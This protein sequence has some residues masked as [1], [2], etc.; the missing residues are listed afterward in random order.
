MFVRDLFKMGI[1]WLKLFKPARTR[2]PDLLNLHFCERID[3]RRVGVYFDLNFAFAGSQVLFLGL[4]MFV[5][6]FFKMGNH[7]LKLFKPACTRFQGLVNLQLAKNSIFAAGEFEARHPNHKEKV[8]LEHKNPVVN[9]WWRLLETADLDGAEVEV[10]PAEEVIMDESMWGVS[11]LIFTEPMG[12]LTSSLLLFLLVLNVICQILFIWILGSTDLTQ[13]TYTPN[14]VAQYRNW[15]RVDAHAVNNYDALTETILS[16]RVCD[17]TV[18]SVAA[19]V[20]DAFGTV[21]EY[22]GDLGSK[23]ILMCGMSLIAWFMT[24]EDEVNS[25]ID[26][27]KLT[28]SIPFGDRT[29]IN[30]NNWGGYNL[31]QLSY[32]RLGIR[33]CVSAARMIIAFC[34]LIQGANY[35]SFTIAMGDLLLNAVA[36]EFVINTDELFF[37]SLAPARAKRVLRMTQGFKLAAVKTF[38]GL[39]LECLWEL[40]FL[41][42][43]MVWVT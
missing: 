36:L 19:E 39:D 10:E 4:G 38:Q 40:L 30:K 15:R 25:T 26:S 1:H 7:W 14:L 12:V 20:S 13:P 32:G 35:L 21:D 23:G 3:F 29:I 31:V 6:G 41:V 34:M 11:V 5:R 17:G 42:F 33:I 43:A 22:L 8:V 27:Y 18:I 24:V 16:K 2:F 28:T 37:S 9:L